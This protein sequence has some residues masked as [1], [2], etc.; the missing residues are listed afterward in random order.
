MTSADT[1]SERDDRRVAPLRAPKTGQLNRTKQ[2]AIDAAALILARDGWSALTIDRVA[3]ESG[4][5]RST[6][7]RRFGSV[8]PLAMEAFDQLLGPA[9]DRESSGDVR[10]DLVANHTQLIAALERGAWGRLVRSLLEASF[11]DPEMAS[12][13]HRATARRRDSTVQFIDAAIARGELPADTD[14]AFIL[15]AIT[16]PIYYRLLF[17][18]HRIDEPAWLAQLVDMAITSAQ[19]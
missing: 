16:G 8:A 12:L 13:L 10:A 6:L 15:D 14:A 1:A 9:P 2:H 19:S 5:G 3:I 7:Y 18:G 17:T 4:V 11:A